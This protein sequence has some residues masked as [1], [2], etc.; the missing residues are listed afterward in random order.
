[1]TYNKYCGTCGQE[2]PLE[3]F[4]KN[5][6]Q[7]DGLQTS[8][9]SCHR[10]QQNAWRKK[11]GEAQQA[12]FKQ[13]RQD[14]I[15]HLGGVCQRCWQAFPYYCYDFHHRD[16]STK[17]FNLTVGAMGRKWEELLLEVEKCDLLCANCHRIRHY[18]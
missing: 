3:G 6:S 14:L 17:S 13:R 9:K 4:G 11:N 15:A 8:C 18:L 12:R 5:R 2:T 1:M 16:A 7:K 10:K